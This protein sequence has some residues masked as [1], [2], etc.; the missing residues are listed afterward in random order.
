MSLPAGRTF[1]VIMDGFDCTRMQ[2][3]MVDRLLSTLYRHCV[4]VI[5]GQQLTPD[6][7]TRF[8]GRLGTTIPHVLGQFCLPEHRDVLIVSNLYDDSGQPVGVHEGGTYWHTDMSYLDRVSVL[9]GLYSLQEPSSGGATEFIDCV[10]GL[11]LLRRQR[12]ERRLPK[13]ICNPALEQAR[14]WHRFGNR[15]RHRASDA[16]YQPL[17]EDQASSLQAGS[18]HPLV[19]RH[20]VTGEESLYAVAAT[21]VRIDDYSELASAT[22]LD[23]LLDFLLAEAPRYSHCYQRGDIVLWDNITTLHRGTRIKKSTSP[24][25]C[26][27][28][29]R[30][31]VDYTRRTS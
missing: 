22:I 8:M 16:P 25:D 27:M 1:P 31:N 29:H 7:Y 23:L 26:R 6:E 24:N 4:V 15:A 13:E 20:P 17:D 21:S 5:R 2:G 30:I 19:M 12:A 9:T 3:D 11:D 14:I 18:Q 28:L 10:T